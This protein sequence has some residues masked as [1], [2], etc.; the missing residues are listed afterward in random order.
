MWESLSVR[1][2]GGAA[3]AFH[4]LLDGLVLHDEMHLVRVSTVIAEHDAIGRRAVQL[5]EAA[6]PQEL[7]VGAAAG[8]ALGAF[9]SYCTTSVLPSLPGARSPGPLPDR[10]L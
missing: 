9:T 5:V 10:T 2:V 7:D 3:A 4:S 6:G 1:G 8:Q